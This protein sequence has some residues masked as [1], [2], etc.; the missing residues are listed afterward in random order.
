MLATTGGHLSTILLGPKRGDRRFALGAG[1]DRP[2]RDRTGKEGT[3]G[4]EMRNLAGKTLG[5][6]V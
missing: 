6:Q 5:G 3:P 1:R 2:G 4:F